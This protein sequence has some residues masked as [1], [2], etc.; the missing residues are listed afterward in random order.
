[1][2]VKSN[3]SFATSEEYEVVGGGVASNRP[4]LNGGEQPLLNIANNGN[5]EDLCKSLGELLCEDSAPK[6]E[7]NMTLRHVPV[8]QT[9]MKVGKSKFYEVDAGKPSLP[10]KGDR[11]K[12]QEEDDEEE[13]VYTS[14][15]S[16]C[17]L[18]LVLHL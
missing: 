18:T 4:L 7:N 13:G 8:N 12:S 14:Q 2:S 16:H 11:E 10:E 5:Q 9:V 15:L 17:K 6:M 1:M 3:D